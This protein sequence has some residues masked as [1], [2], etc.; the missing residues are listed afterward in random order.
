MWLFSFQVQDLQAK[1]PAY[2]KKYGFVY[3]CLMVARML[4][5]VHIFSKNEL[6]IKTWEG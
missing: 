2:A 4:H 5:H 1:G 3:L 6:K